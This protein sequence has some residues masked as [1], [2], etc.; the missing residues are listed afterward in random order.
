[1]SQKK[2]GLVLSSGSARGLAH[3]G[4]LK[5]FQKHNIPIYCIAGSSIGSLVGG[6]FASG[7]P[8]DMLEGLALNLD[9]RKW[10]DVSPP[11]K[12]LIKG[13]K[14]LKI[15]KMVTKNCNIEDLPI[16]FGCVATDLSKGRLVNFTQGN[17]A[18]A[19]RASISIPGV[20]HPLEM[21]GMIL[22]D[23]AVIEMLPVDLCRSLGA[24]I[25]VSVDVSTQVSGVKINTIFDVILQS[26]N[27]MQSEMIKEKREVS[28]I[29]IRPDVQDISPNQ[30]HRSEE[31]I[32][33]GE[34]AC[35]HVIPRIKGLLEG[36]GSL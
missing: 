24:D 34:L 11:R 32:Q 18:H 10:I 23:G 30:F 35:E 26:M 20:F 22:A 25:I 33:A 4:I 13:H 14:I 2:L 5:T 31:A 17:L 21:D 28:D 1:M 29:L 15:L 7:M 6:L 19:I 36:A 8:I 16:P 9:Q 27:I 3:I 12:G